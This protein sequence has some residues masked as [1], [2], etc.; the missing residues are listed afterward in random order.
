MPNRAD[1]PIKH[2]KFSSTDKEFDNSTKI[3]VK[4]PF[5]KVTD[6]FEQ[7]IISEIETIMEYITSHDITTT[8]SIVEIEKEALAKSHRR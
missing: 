4:K 3:V 6:E 1:R 5:K 8:I 7:T 2:V